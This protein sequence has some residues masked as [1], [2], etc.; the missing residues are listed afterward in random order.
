MLAEIDTP[1]V[2]PPPK[3]GPRDDSVGTML[4]LVGG[5]CCTFFACIF[6]IVF[7]FMG[8][9]YG[10]YGGIIMLIALVCIIIGCY[11]GKCTWEGI[12]KASGS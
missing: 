10:M 5:C 9:M 12:Q 1:K 8:A 3:G 2:P 11:S 6:G 4:K 7:L